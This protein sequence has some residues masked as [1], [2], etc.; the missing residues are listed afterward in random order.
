MDMEI[1]M[2]LENEVKCD[3]CGCYTITYREEEKG[4]CCVKCFSKMVG[5]TDSEIY[6]SID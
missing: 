2:E 5:L 1:D 4:K 6:R 3:Y